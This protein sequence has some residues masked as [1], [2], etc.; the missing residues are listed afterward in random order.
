MKKN[1]ELKKKIIN[2]KLFIRSV[3]RN[4]ILGKYLFLIFHNYNLP[5]RF[6]FLTDLE[7]LII[8]K[9]GLTCNVLQ[10]GANDGKTLIQ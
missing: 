10:I 3:M 2:L 5:L 1:I 7:K 4:S 6:I 8:S 9:F